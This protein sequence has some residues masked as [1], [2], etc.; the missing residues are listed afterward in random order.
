MADEFG[1][2]RAGAVERGFEGE[3]DE[4]AVDKALHPAQA[5]AL[6]GPERRAD[7]PEDGNAESLAVHGEAEVDVGKVDEDGERWRRAL[8]GGDERAVLRMDVGGVAQDLGEAHVGDVLG[9]DDALL[10][11]GFHGGAAESGEGGAGQAGAEFGDDL[12]A[13]VVAGGFACGEEDAPIGDGSDG[14]RV[15]GSQRPRRMSSR[16]TFLCRAIACKMALNVP[17]RIGLCAGIGMRWWLGVS[18]SRIMWLPVWW[19]SRY[20]HC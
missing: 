2:D 19:D 17:T 16:V 3:D 6:P 15:D 12:G 10:A 20:S 9:A 11:G 1:V 18:L 8:D 5:A 4:H 7:E 13:V 14:S